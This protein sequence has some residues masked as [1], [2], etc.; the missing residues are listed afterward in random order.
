MTR[1]KRT[2]G[3]RATG[4]PPDAPGNMPR[5]NGWEILKA[6]RRLAPGIPVI[7][8]SGYAEAHVMGGG[9][10]KRPRAFPGKPYGVAALRDTLARAMR[11][12]TAGLR[13]RASHSGSQWGAPRC[14][15]AARVQRSVPHRDGDS[16]PSA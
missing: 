2:V 14:S 11:G 12:D 9:H 7:L 10:G 1:R 5:M 4:C 16:S 3:K 6:L 8:V 15:V 13:I